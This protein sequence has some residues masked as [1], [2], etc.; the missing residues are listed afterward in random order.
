MEIITVT[1]IVSWSLYD[2][3]AKFFTLNIVTLHFAR[4]ITIG[5]NTADIYYGLAFGVSSLIALLFSPFIGR[6]SDLTGKRNLILTFLTIFS[7]VLVV[8]LGF[9]HNVL[10]ALVF[11][12]L[13]KLFIQ[14]AMIVYNALISEVAP[15]N[16]LGLIS[17]FGKMLGFIGALAVLYLMTP[18]KENYGYHRLFQISGLLFFL[19]SLPCIIA[20]RNKNSKQENKKKKFTSFRQLVITFKSTLSSLKSLCE[21][22]EGIKDLLKAS[23]FILCPVNVLILFMAVYLT[24]VFGLDDLAIVNVIATA[25][26]AAIVSSISFGALGD[27][28]GHKKILYLVFALMFVSF[29]LVSLGTARVHAFWLGALFGLIYGALMA[30]PRA[31]AV[32]I[33]PKEKIGEFFGFFAWMGY[34]AGFTGPLVW[35]LVLLVLNPLGVLRYRIAMVLLGLFV[36]PA[37]YY[38]IRV[39]ERKS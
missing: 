24:K 27:R 6:I 19:F 38:F 35:G 11:F 20:T 23:F 10:L 7:A 2:L 18:L 31:L 13:A 3:A 36:I 33:V 34:I 15:A 26:I 8:F 17:G 29:I 21:K 12:A 1:K 22:V 37:L 9:T 30:V 5:K 16:R 32:A 28:I 14:L 4:W 39:P 25:T